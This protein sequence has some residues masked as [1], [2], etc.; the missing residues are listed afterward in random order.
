MEHDAVALESFGNNDDRQSTT[1]FA[2]APEAMNLKAATILLTSRLALVKS[3]A[4]SRTALAKHRVFIDP[5]LIKLLEI[6][7]CYA[8]E[9]L[10]PLRFPKKKEHTAPTSI[11]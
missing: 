3:S 1:E 6:V 10:S 8:N 7:G 2:C 4:A 9:V 5:V 11:S